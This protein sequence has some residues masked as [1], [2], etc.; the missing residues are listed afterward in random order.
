MF[1][2]NRFSLSMFITRFAHSM[3]PRRLKIE[4]MV[5]P[6]TPNFFIKVI[7]KLYV[8]SDV[9]REAAVAELRR[10]D[11][12]KDEVNEIMTSFRGAFEDSVTI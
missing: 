10:A 12:L 2:I 5:E 7:V 1:V 9:R 11:K 4:G 6:F 8:T 3:S